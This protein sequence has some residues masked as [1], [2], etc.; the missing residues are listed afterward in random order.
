[1]A[2]YACVLVRCLVSACATQNVTLQRFRDLSRAH[3]TDAELFSADH[4]RD[5]L[6]QQ[7]AMQGPNF[8]FPSI[9]VVKHY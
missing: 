8:M 7:H 6:Y 1:M 3:R 4:S 9:R 5:W 2:S